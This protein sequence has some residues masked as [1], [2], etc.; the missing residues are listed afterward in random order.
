MKVSIIGAGYVGMSLAALISKK[1]EVSI[2]DID[3]KK[4]DIINSKEF[5]VYDKG[6]KNYLKTINHGILRLQK[7]WTNQFIKLIY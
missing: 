2:W 5:T 6:Q 1:F 4:Q 3:K 7:T